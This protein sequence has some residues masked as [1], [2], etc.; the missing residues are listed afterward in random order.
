MLGIS[1]SS[2]DARRRLRG[3]IRL[4]A[5]GAIGV[6]A[7]G[8]VAAAATR[9]PAPGWHI[10]KLVRSTTTGDFTAM[11]ATGKTTAMAFGSQAIGGT[12]Q[13]VPTSW[14][15]YGSTWEQLPFPGKSG[16][17]VV[18]AGASSYFNVWAFTDVGSGGRVLRWH[19]ADGKW[20]V[21]KT[22]TAPIG[23]AA[24]IGN[25]DVWV[26]GAPGIPEQLGAWRYD[27]H[28][29]TRMAR[30]LDGGSALGPGSVWAFSGTSVDHW[31]GHRWSAANLA[32]LLPERSEFNNPEIT[33][34]LAVSADDV[35]AIGNGERQDQ[36][37]PTVILHYNGHRWAKVA[38]GSYGYGTTPS[39][40][41]SYDGHGGLWLPNPAYGG[42][43]D[44]SYL[45]HYSAGKLTPVA[46]PGGAAG[47][48]VESVSQVPGTS[49]QLAGGFTHARNDL[50]HDLTAVILHS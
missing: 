29:W 39:Q 17:T 48:T 24:V 37:G 3:G 42:G 47:I 10:V 21:A 36:G 4:A 1:T 28:S 49:Q 46:L 41:V 18:A 22:F 16:E 14:L 27:G 2:R 32:R 40:Q 26:F 44:T 9:D 5:A 8:G 45:L 7:L 11:V 43:P 50:L 31:D 13:P 15:H 35:Y 6:M 30:G 23:G 34:I 38:Q 20:T 25:S 33:G 12:G 19:S